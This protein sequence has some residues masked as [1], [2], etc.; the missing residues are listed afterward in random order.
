MGKLI[1]VEGKMY[2]NQYCEI[3]DERV[4][5]SWV[6]KW[7]KSIFSRTMTQNTPSGWPQ[8]GFQIM[9]SLWFTGLLNPQT[10]IPLK[11]SGTMLSAKFKNMRY[12]Q[13]SA[14]TVGESDKGVGWKPIRG[15]SNANIKHS[16]KDSSSYQLKWR[17]Y[18]VLDSRV[19]T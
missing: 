15:M 18:Q 1:E 7:G 14:W 5:K 12:H 19:S 3:L 11:P 10:S 16:Q 13:R 4:L 6:L 8:L 2:A 9:I 17:S